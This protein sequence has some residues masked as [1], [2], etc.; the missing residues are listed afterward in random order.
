M[1]FAVH[2]FFDSTSERIIRSAWEEL[3]N[4]GISSSMHESAYRPHLSLALYDELNI[5]ASASRLKLFAEMFSPFALTI[6][7]L[8]FFPAGKAFV[9]LVPT[10]TQKLLDIHAYIHRLLEDMGKPSLSNHIPGYWFPHCT[11]ALDVRPGL[12]AQ[13]IEIGLAMPFPMYCQV[14]EIG[15]VECWP[16]KQLCSFGLGGG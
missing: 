10:V 5:T 11:L 8:G 14:E 9:F 3:A 15:V 2:L 4:S 6:S 1:P 16:V 13:A 7:S 12:T